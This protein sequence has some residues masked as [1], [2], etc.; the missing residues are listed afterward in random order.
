MS[1]L[2]KKILDLE[3]KVKILTSKLAD[4]TRNT[5]SKSII[6]YSK[7]KTSKGQGWWFIQGKWCTYAIYAD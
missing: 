3:H 6:P 7:L 4:L 2:N 1:S 5:E